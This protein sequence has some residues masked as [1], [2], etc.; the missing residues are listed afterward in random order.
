LREEEDGSSWRRWLVDVVIERWES[1]IHRWMARLAIVCDEGLLLVP[2]VTVFFGFQI[3]GCFYQVD[4]KGRVP[5]I[6]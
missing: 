2:F 4:K 1:W 6:N 3:K 5:S